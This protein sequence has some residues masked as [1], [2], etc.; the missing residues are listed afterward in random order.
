MSIEKPRL[1][2]FRE[3]FLIICYANFVKENREGLFECA[4]SVSDLSM[5]FLWLHSSGRCLLCGAAVN[6]RSRVMVARLPAGFSVRAVIAN[7][8]NGP[9]RPVVG[10]IA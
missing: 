9:R 1:K 2:Q 10:S 5:P 4:V 7:Q 8:R 6:V 3:I